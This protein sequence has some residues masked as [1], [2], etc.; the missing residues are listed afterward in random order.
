MIIAIGGGELTTGQTLKIDKFIVSAAKKPQPKLL[1]IPT[2]S[3]DA[4]GYIE[5]VKKTF[6]TLCCTFAALCLVTKE[7]Q[8][9]EIANMIRDADII[10][11]GG[12]NTLFMMETWKKFQVDKYLRE[13]YQKGTVLSGLSA[14]AICWFSSGHSDSEFFTENENP[15]FIFV[16]GLGMIP[17]VVCPHYDEEDRKSFDQMILSKKEPG[18]AL[19]SLT[20]LV[21]DCNDYKIIRCNETSQAYIFTNG[22]KEQLK[23]IDL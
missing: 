22:N 18:T 10:Y 19:E 4:P 21:Y 6:E 20:A 3:H 17:Y 8:E 14:G 16:D 13:A 5:I 23:A 15:E 9:G 1:F 11:V 12:G 7:Y 2:A